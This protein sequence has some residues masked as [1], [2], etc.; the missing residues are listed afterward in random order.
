MKK[1]LVAACGCALTLLIAVP[2]FVRIGNQS[3]PLGAA[4]YGWYLVAVAGLFVGLWMSFGAAE[5]LRRPLVEIAMALLTA[6]VLNHFL[7][8]DVVFEG[9]LDGVH[10]SL[11][12]RSAFSY[13]ATLLYAAAGAGAYAL[14]RRRTV[15]VGALSALAVA[16][17]LSTVL[18]QAVSRG[19]VTLVA[20]RPAISQDLFR[21]S[22]KL[23]IIH[24]LPDALQTDLVQEVLA[25][26]PTLRDR[27]TGFRLYAG[28]M[29]AYPT[30]AP[31]LPT[32]FT[33]RYFDLSHGYHIDEIGKLFTERSFTNVLADAGFAV[34]VV[35]LGRAYCGARYAN[36]ITATFGDLTPR[37]ALDAEREEHLNLARLLD[38]ALARVVP[39]LL[40]PTVY[41]R[42]NWSLSRVFRQVNGFG[43]VLDP[44]FLE[45]ARHMRVDAD[46]PPTYL[47]YHY[48]GTHPPAQWDAACTFTGPMRLART[49]L[50]DQTE[51]VLNGIAELAAAL[52]RAGVFDRT[53]IVVN[54]DHGIGIPPAPVGL[55]LSN[56]QV[57]A[58][59]LGKAHAALLIKGIG[60]HGPFRTTA[61]P[62]AH[63]DIRPTILGMAGLKD[64][65]PGADLVN[66][67]APSDRA[68]MYHV[69]YD[70]RWG[71]TDPVSHVRFAVGRDA[72]NAEDWSV[73]AFVAARESPKTFGAF[74]TRDL[75]LLQSG[76]IALKAMDERGVWVAGR[77]VSVRLAARDP[78]DNA[79]T[80]TLRLP[81]ANSDARVTITVNGALVGHN[82]RVTSGD[83]AWVRTQACLPSDLAR[84]AH[85]F[86][87]LQFSSASAV[88]GQRVPVSA[89]LRD[90]AFHRAE[91]CGTGG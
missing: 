36:C 69:L 16:V 77:R 25:R 75:T 68:R 48:I 18:A 72:L 54:S 39:T 52:R 41:D 62:T 58:E 31:T 64:E 70:F 5:R 47:F 28:H 44:F 63:I 35:G 50:L 43:T 20:E 27:L 66:E 56:P 3:L 22:A 7:L 91:R 65:G 34:N 45:W 37:G 89:L 67:A 59:W 17:A 82:I 79:L 87:A 46:A 32:I 61:E 42:G 26:N 33:G 53:A 21:L 86:V 73:D 57:M 80:V 4:T 74:G 10:A 78:R 30:T 13:L 2:L 23:N 11:A 15:G 49:P 60:D 6:A 40:V 88:A 9:V 90:I 81:Q 83:S 71:G 85:E 55:P 12:T 19:G 51:C 1:T 14:L 29:G 84:G 76:A 24:L 38:L 8:F